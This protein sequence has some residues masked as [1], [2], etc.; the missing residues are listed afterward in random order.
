MSEKQF[1]KCHKDNPNSELEEKI[2]H[3]MT[4]AKLHLPLDYLDVDDARS[5]E[6]SGIVVKLPTEILL[7][8]L[9]HKYQRFLN[10]FDLTN[11]CFFF[12]GAGMS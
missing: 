9:G 3:P 12:S 10:G 6:T 11:I 7:H 1:L 4:F 5:L 8:S 2:V